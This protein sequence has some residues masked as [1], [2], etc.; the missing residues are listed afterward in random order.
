LELVLI[1]ITKTCTLFN[2]FTPRHSR[3]VWRMT[4]QLWRSITRERS[5]IGYSDLFFWK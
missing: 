3:V 1:C 4:Y 5:R 2:P